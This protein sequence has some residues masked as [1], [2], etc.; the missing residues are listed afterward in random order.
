MEPIHLQRETYKALQGNLLMFYTGQQRTASSILAEQKGNMESAVKMEILKGMVELVDELRDA[1]Y[2]GDLRKFGHI[3]HRGWILKQQLASKISNS[4]IKDLY[5]LALKN[6][7]IGGKLLGAGGGGFLLLY[8]EQEK[9]RQ[10]RAAF[11]GLKELPFK[12][13]NEGSKLIHVDDEY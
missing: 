10:L 12:F 13:E 2:E 11:S 9:Q 8:C 4:R 1:L 3:L 6:G 5:E 7:A